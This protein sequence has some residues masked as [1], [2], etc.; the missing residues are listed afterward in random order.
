[1]LDLFW[2]FEICILNMY[3]LLNFLLFNFCY[4]AYFNWLWND[5]ILIFDINRNKL[6]HQFL[7]IYVVFFKWINIKKRIFHLMEFSIFIY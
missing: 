1:M 5:N 7:N 3:S 6:F 2:K 4:I